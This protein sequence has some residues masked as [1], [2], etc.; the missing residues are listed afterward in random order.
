[1]CQT[2]AK[3]QAVYCNNAC[4]VAQTGIFSRK[5]KNQKW[6]MALISKNKTIS[7]CVKHGD[8]CGFCS[9]SSL[10]CLLLTNARHFDASVKSDQMMSISTRTSCFWFGTIQTQK[11]NR[12]EKIKHNCN[13]ADEFEQHDRSSGRW[14]ASHGPQPTSMLALISSERRHHYSV[15]GRVCHQP[16]G[17]G[18]CV[19]A[20]S[21]WIPSTIHTWLFVQLN[22][23][24][25][26]GKSV[27]WT[28]KGGREMCR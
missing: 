25:T 5:E 23:A 8:L 3:K 15:R 2:G 12:K 28:F 21:P 20:G 16:M 7:V 17:E 26:R 10:K 13:E 24:T 14:C 11:N 4:I 19:P 9:T 27:V 6:L 22:A 1:M 18:F